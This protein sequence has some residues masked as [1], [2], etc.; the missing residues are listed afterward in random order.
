MCSAPVRSNSARKPQQPQ[1]PTGAAVAGIE[2]ENATVV[3]LPGRAVRFPGGRSRRVPGHDHMARSIG[4]DGTAVEAFRPS[5]NGA[6]RFEFECASG[7]PRVPHRHVR[8][9][10]CCKWFRPMPRHVHATVPSESEL[11]TTN[12]SRRQGAARNT[13]HAYWSGD[14]PLAIAEPDVVQIAARRIAGEIDDVYDPLP[15]DDRLRLNA[16]VRYRQHCDGWRRA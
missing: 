5:G 15:I 16:T 4:G 11:G 2:A 14:L 3:E 12:R 10:V 8:R 6:L 7:G 13:V 1:A 9:I